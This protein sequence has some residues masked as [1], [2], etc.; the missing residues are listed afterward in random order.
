VDPSL[1]P[2]YDGENMKITNVAGAT[3]YLYREYREG[4][5]L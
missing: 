1:P 4:W 2:R 3:K 5:E